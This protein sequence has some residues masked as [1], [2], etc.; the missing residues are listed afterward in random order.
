MFQVL[1]PD[2]ASPSELES[3][4]D[5]DTAQS[6]NRS[7][8]DYQQ[9]QDT[10]IGLT[11]IALGQHGEMGGLGNLVN[12]VSAWRKFLLLVKLVGAMEKINFYYFV[13]N[14]FKSLHL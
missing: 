1:L 6:S 4:S 13:L 2:N 3:P 11:G 9:I 5:L 8:T 12:P 14:K 10:Q 7:D